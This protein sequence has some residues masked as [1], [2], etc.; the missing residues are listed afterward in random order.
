L[1]IVGIR[2]AAAA[3]ALVVF[4]LGI[5]APFRHVMP[6]TQN[7]GHP[8]FLGFST[9]EHALSDRTATAAGSMSSLVF[10]MVSVSL[11]KGLEVFLV[12]P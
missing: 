9:V 4:L 1:G 11:S 8:Q 3:A 7:S 5:H 2:A 12:L 10:I 6:R